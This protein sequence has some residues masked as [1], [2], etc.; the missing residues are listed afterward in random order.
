MRRPGA[1]ELERALPEPEAQLLAAVLAAADARGEALYLVGGPVRDLLLGVRP[2]DL[3]LLVEAKGEAA[4][5]LAR[6]AAPAGARVVAHERFGTVS[7]R[8]GAASLDLALPRRE[9]YARPGALPETSP[10][11]LEEDLARRDFTVNALALP[12]SRAARARHTGILAVEEGLADLEA[13]RLRVLHRASFRDDP[14]RALRAARLAA[15]LGFSITRGTRAALRDAL[16]S[17][18]FGG[19]SG[20]RLRR[21][22]EKLFEDAAL[23]QG[24]AHA[25]RLLSDWQVLGALEPELVLPRESL[26]PLRRLGRS[27]AAPPWRGPRWR[28]WVAGLALW[29][30]PLPA[31]LR[32]RALRRLAIS[33]QAAE[34][35][36]A[37]ARSR[38]ARLAALA[39]SRGRGALDSLLAPLAEEELFAL[40]AWAPPVEQRRIARY[41]NEDRLR[42]APF[43]GDDAKALGLAG[44]SVGRVLVRVRA[45]FLDGRARSREEALALAREL[46]RRELRR[47]HR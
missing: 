20:E 29:L 40:H 24:P 36:A 26:A 17:G 11:T 1:A 15:R 33:G 32:R 23:G 44:P 6:A 34:L 35:V 38:E 14:T 28:P 30:A 39:K 9:R 47:S 16:R 37:L 25:L 19:V 10:G 2:S 46:A 4:A 27:V 5:E 8:A 3:D 31:G 13:R 7:L 12:L 21:E 42:R 41:A 18:A 45:A 43:S 22:F